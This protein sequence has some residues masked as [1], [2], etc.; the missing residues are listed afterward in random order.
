MPLLPALAVYLDDAKPSAYVVVHWHGRKVA[1]IKTTWRKL[2]AAAALP[3]WFIPKT[4]RHTIATWLRQRGVPAGDA[5]LLGHH[6]GGTTDT[7]TRFDPAYM[8]TVRCALDEIF[9]ALAK[10][11]PRLRVLLTHPA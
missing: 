11:V 1:P 9:K 7:Y 4:V 2:R 5:G 3:A 10:D 8:G 6:T